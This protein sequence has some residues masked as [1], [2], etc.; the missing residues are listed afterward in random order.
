MRSL[1]IIFR[2]LLV[3][4]GNA[5]VIASSSDI[6]KS[7]RL[8]HSLGHESKLAPR[9]TITIAP[10]SDAATGDQGGHGSSSS[11]LVATFQPDDSVQFDAEAFDLMVENHDLY[12]LVVL[13][14]GVDF[15]DLSLF[16]SSPSPNNT[17]YV[18]ASVPGCSLRRSNLREEIVLSIGP[19]G[20]LMSVSYR[21]LISPLAPKTCDKLKPLSEKPEAVFGRDPKSGDVASPFKTA[22]SFESHKPMMAIPTVLPQSRP[23]PG[24]KWYRRNAKNNPSPLLGGG[25]ANQEGGGIPFVDEEAPPAWKTSFL[26]RYWYIIL[27]LAIMGLFGGVEEEPPAQQRQGK[28]AG[29]V[30]QEGGLGGATQQV[31]KQRRGKRD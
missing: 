20:K 17:R 6:S 27:P 13:E 14:E 26:Y 10:S 15:H 24:L 23:P 19:T 30:G 25:N 3:F 22:V 29:N 1:C 12:T 18:S 16:P 5:V 11:G 8:Y 21:P 2:F 4:V 9:G 28:Q 31:P 7:Y